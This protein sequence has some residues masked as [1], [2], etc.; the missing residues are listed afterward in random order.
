[1]LSTLIEILSLLHQIFPFTSDRK[2]QILAILLHLLTAYVLANVGYII[3][4][5][6]YRYLYVYLFSNVRIDLYIFLYLSSPDFYQYL[7]LLATILS[8]SAV[9]LST[10]LLYNT[11]LQTHKLQTDEIEALKHLFK[12][13]ID[14]LDTEHAIQK[15]AERFIGNRLNIKKISYFI[16][17]LILYYCSFIELLIS[18]SKLFN[19]QFLHPHH[20]LRMW[21]PHQLFAVLLA[22]HMSHTLLYAVSDARH[23]LYPPT[24]MSLLTVVLRRPLSLLEL[25]SPKNSTAIDMAGKGLKPGGLVYFLVS[26]IVSVFPYLPIVSTNNKMRLIALLPRPQ[27]VSCYGVPSN[28][29]TGECKGSKWQQD[30]VLRHLMNYLMEMRVTPLICEHSI[31]T[32]S[33]K[34]MAPKGGG[35]EKV[36]LQGRKV[37]LS[38]MEGPLMFLHKLASAVAASFID[39]L[40]SGNVGIDEGLVAFKI[41]LSSGIPYQYSIYY[42]N[43]SEEIKYCYCKLFINNEKLYPIYIVAAWGEKTEELYQLLSIKCLLGLE[44]KNNLEIPLPV[45]TANKT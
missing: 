11:F 5:I 30:D 15:F 14:E 44:G 31:I 38:K 41:E 9:M 26:L 34:K 40:N 37:E 12:K 22:I 19:L 24:L 1:M 2:R 18:S 45:K 4:S 6:G 28:E 13:A 36:T 39:L 3:V 29:R 42:R 27:R 21:L 43:R 7:Y 10:Y 35:E 16:F 23:Y 8:I 20:A 17:L 32:D 33:I 25:S